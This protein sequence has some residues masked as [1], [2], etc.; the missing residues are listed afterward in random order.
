MA[1]EA[2]AVAAIAV[3]MAVDPEDPITAVAA[4]AE[5]SA[6]EGAAEAA[7]AESGMVPDVIPTGIDPLRL[8]ITII[9]TDIIR[10]IPTTIAAGDAAALR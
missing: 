5:D 10:I 4:V 9:I 3:H 8:R 1:A 6:P 2:A 7:G